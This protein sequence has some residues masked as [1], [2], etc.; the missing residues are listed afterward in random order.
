MDS[1]DKEDEEEETPD[2]KEV[3]KEEK[4]KIAQRMRKQGVPIESQDP[5]TPDITSA[6]GMSQSWISK[7]TQPA[8]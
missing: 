6:I 1:W 4:R 2:P 3:S 5:D 7:N 8:E